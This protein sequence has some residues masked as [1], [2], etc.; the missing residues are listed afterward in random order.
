M[1]IGHLQRTAGNRAVRQVLED[2]GPSP[3]APAVPP[4]V[5]EALASG[6]GQVLD[7][8]TRATLES[9][10]Q[11]DL[12]DMR[13]HTGP[14]ADR[15]ARL[16]GARAYAT[17]RDIA[18]RA[19]EYAPQTPAGLHLLAHELAHVLQMRGTVTTPTEI[20]EPESTWEGSADRAAAAA[21]SGSPVMVASG[22]PSAVRLTPDPGLAHYLKRVSLAI[23][24]ETSIV[25]PVNDDQVVTAILGALRGLD[26]TDVDNLGPVT[27]VVRAKA[28]SDVFV[29][30]LRAAQTTRQVQARHKQTVRHLQVER[31][32]PWGTH[33]PATPAFAAAEVVGR[34]L[35][36]VIEVAGHIQ[37]FVEGVIQGL[38]EGFGKEFGEAD[39]AALRKKL[40]GSTVVAAALPPL[41]GVAAGH[42]I[43]KEVYDGVKGVIDIVRDWSAFKEAIGALLQAM[44]SEAG[45]EVGTAIGFDVA[46]QS[47]TAIKR[48]VANDNAVEFTYKLGMLAGPIVVG[49]VLS[50]TGVGAAAVAGVKTVTTSTRLAALLGRL[51]KRFPKIA[52]LIAKIRGRTPEPPDKPKLP[53]R[54]KGPGRK[55]APEKKKAPE[56]KKGTPPKDGTPKEG[57][58]KAAPSK[59]AQPK[60]PP[61]ETPESPEAPR[62]PAHPGMLTKKIKPVV[63]TI[64]KKTMREFVLKKWGDNKFLHDLADILP[65]PNDSAKL[66]KLVKLLR[67]WKQQTGYAYEW[68]EGALDAIDPKNPGSLSWKHGTLLL[69]RRLGKDVGQLSEEVLH[70]LCAQAAGFPHT[71]RFLNEGPEHIQQYWHAGRLLELVVRKKGDVG[72]LDNML[73]ATNPG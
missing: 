54:K 3:L 73:N 21:A 69:E 53:E 52:K 62:K 64:P 43:A 2:L 13:I 25:G 32:G 26:L 18:F 27:Q 57:P 6:A 35:E 39:K 67:S 60:K 47:A 17:G 34:P 46:Q 31:R 55:E 10:F 28:S 56:D 66:K 36:P 42:G 40:V 38:S 33:G 72:D 4:I 23:K 48:S 58:S 15:S 70:E 71:A 19:G 59:A 45:R 63:R 41:M 29:R 24:Q 61:K 44:V 49:A 9:R 37:G 16:L 50:V 7:S 1:A 51:A 22:A 11:M 68:V 65:M 14:R 30:F 20:G 8:A 5:H 12:G